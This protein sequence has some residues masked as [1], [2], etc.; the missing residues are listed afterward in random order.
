MSW[1]IIDT[2]RKR[3][4]E[5]E[6]LIPR[7]HAGRLAICL[8]YPERYHIAMSSLGFTAV[9]ALCNRMPDVV[10]ER[11]FLPDKDEL[12]EYRASRTP[13]LSL[14]SQRPVADFDVI[15]FSVSF[16]SDYANIPDLLTLAG[17]P[18]FAG[19]RTAAMPLVMAGG[20][21]LFLNPEPVAE[22]RCAS[23]S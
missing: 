23:H 1:K 15:A 12:A 2:Y 11:A 5:E 14:E 21:A 10:C 4:A 9:H 13:L 7:K 18:C 22:R 16:E 3:L 19:E 8:V 6:W 17:L 20:A